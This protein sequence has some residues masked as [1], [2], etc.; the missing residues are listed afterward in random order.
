MN[1]ALIDMVRTRWKLHDASISFV[2]A[3]E[4]TVYKVNTAI[5]KA[6]L[7]F[8][9]KG[10]RSFA[11][12]KSEL[13]WMA[14]LARCGV[15][16]PEPMPASDGSAIQRCD[17]TIVSMLRWV[18]A[19]PFNP[20]TVNSTLYFE[21]G[22]TL[23]KLHKLSDSWALPTAFSRPT[24]ELFSD[25]PSWGRYWENQLLTKKQAAQFLQFHDDAKVVIRSLKT[26]DTGLI[27]ADLVPDNVLIATDKLALL[28]F[29]DSGFGYRLF[30][31][32]TITHRSKRFVGGDAFTEATI[33][34][35]R[36]QRQLETNNLALFEAVRACTYL[37][38]N[39][40]RMQEAGAAKRHTRFVSEAEAAIAL[41]YKNS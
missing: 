8:H 26:L 27:H 21:L 17:D 22:S 39:S 19:K 9:R 20:A 2:A 13:D 36:S 5:G 6:A 3:R 11:Q 14:M 25:Q 15:L 35:Y 1:D 29:D 34:G 38:W 28:D 40:S 16:V 10:Y 37:G 31:V 12:I 23:A 4:N 30:D 18:D 32:A 41:F 7:R 24:W 33:A